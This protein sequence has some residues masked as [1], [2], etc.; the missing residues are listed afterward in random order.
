MKIDYAGNLDNTIAKLKTVGIT[1]IVYVELDHRQTGD[2]A[3]A[4]KITFT[5]EYP[6]IPS[7]PSDI[8]QI[9]SGIDSVIGQ[10]NQ[11]DF[12]GISDQ[13][14]ITIKNINAFVS[15]D[16]MQRIINNLDNMAA[17]LDNAADKVNKIISDGRLDDILDDTRESIR[18]AK[19]VI[20]RLKAEINGLN[21]AEISD[22]AD[23]LIDNTSRKVK[24]IG[25]ELQATSE[26]LRR[27]SEN[28][29]EVLDRL[30]ADP[31]DIIFSEPPAKK[32]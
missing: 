1:G 4:P 27:A 21:L 11:I 2:L 23:K 26:N 17:S 12:K 30:K 13:L 31:S 6:V 8:K 5:P 24:L 20:K 3:N 32:R 16:E 25:E 7:N 29:D 15:G 10:M 22:K 14:K 28:L 9:F 18:E 19:A